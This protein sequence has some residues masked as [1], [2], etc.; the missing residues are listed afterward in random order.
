M[1]IQQKLEMQKLIMESMQKGITF[2]PPIDLRKDLIVGFGYTM[3]QVIEMSDNAVYDFFD[4]LDSDYEEENELYPVQ[5][6]CG[7]NE[8]KCIGYDDSAWTS[9]CYLFQCPKC[10]HEF[11]MHESGMDAI[12]EHQEFLKQLNKEMKE[13]YSN[14]PTWVL[15]KY[16]KESEMDINSFTNGWEFIQEFTV[17]DS[18]SHFYKNNGIYMKIE[19]IHVHRNYEILILQK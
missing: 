10:S 18:T 8:V 7:Q 4:N 1:K 6:K 2:N 5:C 16:V 13:I 9:N 12:Y 15:L 3:N 11:E 17:I 19:Y 14:S